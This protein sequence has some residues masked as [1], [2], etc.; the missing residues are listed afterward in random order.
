MV[1]ECFFGYFCGFGDCVD[2]DCVDVVVV[3]EL[4]GGV[5]Y[6]GGVGSE[7]G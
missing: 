3:E 7:G 5:E 2:V 1:V 4:G 6:V